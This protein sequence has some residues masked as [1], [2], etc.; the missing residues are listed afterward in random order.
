MAKDEGEPARE[1]RA[2]LGPVESLRPDVL[3]LDNDLF[4]VVKVTDTLKHAGYATRSVKTEADFERSL[5]ERPPAVAMVNT[6][7]RGVDFRRAISLAREIGIPVVAFGSHVDL[8]TQEA[9]R[10][11]G[12]TRVITNARVASDLPGVLRR[13]LDG[14]PEEK[15]ASDGE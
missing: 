15:P 12:A 6:A 4:F 5:R 11:A 7:A 10:N 14:A 8:P 9:A 2:T 13:A 3:L 1:R